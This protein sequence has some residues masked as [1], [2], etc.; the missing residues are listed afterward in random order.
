MNA[1]ISETIKAK[2]LRL[3]MQIFAQCKFQQGATPNIFLRVIG[4]ILSMPTYRPN[5][6]CNLKKM[7]TE[8]ELKNMWFQ[9]DSATSQTTNVTMDLLKTKFG[10]QV[11]SRNDP[12]NWPPLSCDLTPLDYFLWVNVKS[13]V[14]AYY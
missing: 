4:F 13:I 1:D 14:Y 11:I 6:V 9:Q 7:I 12:V 5:Q 10:L 3:D 8:K 2:R